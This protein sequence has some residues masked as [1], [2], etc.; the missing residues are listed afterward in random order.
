MPKCHQ[1]G[2]LVPYSKR[3]CR[4]LE[5]I[6]VLGSQP[7][8]DRSQ[9]PSGRLPFISARPTVT[10]IAAEH[11]RLLAGTKLHCLVT[12][13]HVCRAAAGIRIREIATPPPLTTRSRSHTIGE[14]DPPRRCVLPGTC[15]SV[16]RITQNVIDEC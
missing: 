9:N 5:L 13:E 7:A 8:G 1:K 4:L 11:R 3:A 10:F 14:R 15:L 16:R 2:K 6:P 12:E